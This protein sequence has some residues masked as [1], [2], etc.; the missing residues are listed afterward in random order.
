MTK[1]LLKMSIGE[2]IK[3]LR[4]EKGITQTALAKEIGVTNEWLCAI[5][6]RRKNLS[7]DL[8]YKIADNL[9]LTDKE[10]ENF[11]KIVKNKSKPNSKF[12]L[13]VANMELRDQLEDK[14]QMIKNLTKKLSRA[15][16]WLKEIV[17]NHRFTPIS[18]AEKALKE[19]TE[20]KNDTKDILR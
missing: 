8:A 10:K 5:E 6:N 16:W 12:L 14:E 9:H 20:S 11:I 7:I 15:E 17:E 19:L 1:E 3:E 13:Q 2:I 18:T 4:L